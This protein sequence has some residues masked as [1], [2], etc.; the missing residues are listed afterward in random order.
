M[1][2]ILIF[3]LDFTSVN[4]SEAITFKFNVSPKYSLLGFPVKNCSDVYL[5]HE[6]IGISLSSP[7]DDSILIYMVIGSPSGSLKQIGSTL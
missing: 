2:V 1:P 7:S 5:Y 4:P 3:K 6:S